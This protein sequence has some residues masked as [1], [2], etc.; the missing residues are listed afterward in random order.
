ML[1]API[2]VFTSKNQFALVFI[3]HTLI[4]GVSS[5]SFEKNWDISL[6]HTI[7]LTGDSLAIIQ[8]I[9]TL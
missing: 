1:N 6:V 7:Y 4:F 2:E 5:M 9:A 3:L 8:L